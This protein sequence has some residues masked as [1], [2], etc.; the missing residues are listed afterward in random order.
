M[1]E[2]NRPLILV[3]ED[4]PMLARI[5][6][7]ALR[8]SG[9]DAASAPDGERG[10]AMFSELRPALVVTDVMMPRSDGFRLTRRIRSVDREVPILFLSARSSSDDVVEGFA[11][12]GDDY[13]RK[14]F[15]MNELL[16]RIEALLR[17][18]EGRRPAGKVYAV[19][20]Y[21]FD[22]ER[23]M[24]SRGQ[25]RTKLS[26]REAAILAMLVEGG[27]GIVENSRILGEIW[28]DDSYYAQRSLN[29]YVTRLRHRLAADRRIEIVS[30]R[31]VGYRLSVRRA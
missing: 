12:G 7:D 19:G 8:Q 22:A 4:E 27:D 15:A 21:T 25:E 30:V 11:S 13:L 31:N 6:C 2:T 16:A 26:A 9:Y 3:V 17:R 1:D 18:R 29:V 23:W 24:L 10:L 5:V 14:P 28:G 20:D